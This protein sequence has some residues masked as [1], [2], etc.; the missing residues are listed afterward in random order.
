M[1]VAGTTKNSY[2]MNSKIREGKPGLAVEV[3]EI[4]HFELGS[5]DLEFQD[6]LKLLS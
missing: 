4:C 5:K 2:L 6:L 1:H 3:M